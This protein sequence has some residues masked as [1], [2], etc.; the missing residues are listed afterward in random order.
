MNE[1]NPWSLPRYPLGGKLPNQPGIYFAMHGDEILYIGMTSTSFAHR[2]VNHHRMPE[3]RM[4]SGVE[5]ACAPIEAGKDELLSIESKM[6]ATLNP[7]LNRK[8]IVSKSSVGT[9]YLAPNP[10]PTPFNP[11]D[12]GHR[13]LLS[14]EDLYV[15]TD[16]IEMAEAYAGESLTAGE[17]EDLQSLSRLDI[18]YCEDIN[19]RL[20]AQ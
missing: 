10:I 19:R 16:N 17:I 9:R 20:K 13:V 18:V 11:S 7:I 6:I 8:R 12:G 5:L 3:L 1:I 14:W 4:V 2:W 15:L